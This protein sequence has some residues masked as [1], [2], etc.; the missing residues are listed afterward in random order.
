MFI[1]YRTYRRYRTGMYIRKKGRNKRFNL[2]PHGYRRYRTYRLYHTEVRKKDKNE[3]VVKTI[4]P[5]NVCA[6]N[7]FTT[8][9]HLIG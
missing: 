1:Q 3:I 6:K 4:V 8:S 7:I 2:F 9:V 5:P